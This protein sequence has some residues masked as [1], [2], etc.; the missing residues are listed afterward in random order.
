MAIEGLSMA[1]RA[2][3]E[4]V[5]EI[6]PAALALQATLDASQPSAQLSDR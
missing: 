6:G 4:P 5:A 3:I 2:R 1:A